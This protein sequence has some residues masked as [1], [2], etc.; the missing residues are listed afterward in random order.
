MSA[1]WRI[2]IS[3]TPFST[4]SIS[5]S[6]CRVPSGNTHSTLPCFSAFM[7][8]RMALMSLSVREMGIMCSLSCKNQRVNRPRIN[9]FFPRKYSSYGHSHASTS[10]SKL[11]LWLAISR[12]GAF[13]VRILSRSITLKG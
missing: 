8:A 11:L 4:R 1:F 6:G 3:A 10:A 5:L 9:S 7:Q 2:A 13:G 12:Y